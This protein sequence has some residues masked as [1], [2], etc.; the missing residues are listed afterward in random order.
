MFALRTMHKVGDTFF[1]TSHI[2]RM[3]F[4]SAP[5]VVFCE[6]NRGVLNIG[7]TGTRSA[8]NPNVRSTGS[9]TAVRDFRL[10]LDEVAEPIFPT[11]LEATTA[12]HRR[13]R[14][15]LQVESQD[16]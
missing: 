10:G 9:S 6:P 7:E 1:R 13:D 2:S 15:S 12:R 11:A 16:G 8:K 14:S 5:P 3:D 4:L